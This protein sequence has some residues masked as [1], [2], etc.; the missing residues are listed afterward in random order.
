MTYNELKKNIKKNKDKEFDRS[1]SIAVLA[2][3]SHI[4]SWVFFL[5]WLH[6]FILSG[7][8]SPLI[9]S[10]ILGHLLTWGV[11]LSVSYHFAFS[12]C[13]W[14]SQGKNA[15]VVCH[16]LLQWITFCQIFPP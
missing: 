13:S 1:L 14:G 15:E 9:S 4:H 12:Y 8:I 2:I 10:S 6:P 7:V 3:T 16:S 5:L 11:S